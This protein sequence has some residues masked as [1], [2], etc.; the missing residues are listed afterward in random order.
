M[1]FLS[2]IAFFI[3]NTGPFL[4]YFLAC[5]MSLIASYKLSVDTTN[6]ELDKFVNLDLYYIINLNHL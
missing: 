3:S 6:M 2:F 5:M 1:P 4:I